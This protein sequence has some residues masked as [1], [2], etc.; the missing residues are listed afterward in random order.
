[1]CKWE[2]VNIHAAKMEPRKRIKKHEKIMRGRQM[3]GQMVYVYVYR[4]R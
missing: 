2:R 4:G 3:L 1:M